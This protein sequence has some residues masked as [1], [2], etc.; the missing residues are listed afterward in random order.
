MARRGYWPC[1]RC[2]V[3][4]TIKF[5]TSQQSSSS[6]LAARYGA[7]DDEAPKRGQGGGARENRHVAKAPPKSGLAG[8]GTPLVTGKGD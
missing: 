3:S 2:P 1:S 7:L 5:I 6:P 4:S 8:K